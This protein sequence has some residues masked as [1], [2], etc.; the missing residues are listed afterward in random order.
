MFDG[1]VLWDQ[2]D[3]LGINLEVIQRD[4]RHAVLIRDHLGEVIFL[5]EPELGELETQARA[6]N[7]RLFLGPVELAL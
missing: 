4:G 2:L 6:R 5:D 7:S 3:D 1:D